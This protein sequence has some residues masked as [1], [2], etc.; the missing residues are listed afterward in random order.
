MPITVSQF[1][2]FNDIFINTIAGLGVVPEDRSL[3]R[4]LLDS[5]QKDIVQSGTPGPTPGPTPGTGDSDLVGK[6]YT[7]SQPLGC[8]ITAYWMPVDTGASVSEQVVK[9]AVRRRTTGWVALG[10][11]QGEFRMIDSDAVIGW[12]KG[13]GTISV[14]FFCVK[15]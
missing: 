11:P 1:K 2:K 4:S 14:C 8:D 9:F 10:F 7:F 5:T 3:I 6:G 12:V 15:C 13:D